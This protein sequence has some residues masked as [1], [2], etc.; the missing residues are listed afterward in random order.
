MLELNNSCQYQEVVIVPKRK[1][2][3]YCAHHALS[4]V[5]QNFHTAI[6]TH[7][8]LWELHNMGTQFYINHT[9]F[10][11]PKLAIVRVLYVCVYKKPETY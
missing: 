10:L 4:L 9:N 8:T 3:A 6:H 2:S 7:L 1:P 5:P 11:P